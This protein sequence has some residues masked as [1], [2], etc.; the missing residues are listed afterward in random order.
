[1]NIA[2]SHKVTRTADPVAV[3]VDGELV[4]MDI[5]SGNYIGLSPV[6]TRIWELLEQPRSVGDL[7][8]TLEAEYDV[9]SE[10]CRAETSAF[11]EQLV[12]NGL[13]RLD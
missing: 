8:A 1:M 5:E 10:V 11:L 4:M 2:D 6:G 13:V 9:P 3:E 12:Q 7:T